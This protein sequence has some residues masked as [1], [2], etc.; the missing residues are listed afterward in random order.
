VGPDRVSACQP[1]QE[2]VAPFAIGEQLTQVTP[3]RLGRWLAQQLPGGA[4]RPQDGAVAI[5]P[6]SGQGRVFE[7]RLEPVVTGLASRGATVGHWSALVSRSE[8]HHYF[9]SGSA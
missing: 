6:T 1:G 2:L 5:D 7:E 9:R 4:V 8:P 3:G